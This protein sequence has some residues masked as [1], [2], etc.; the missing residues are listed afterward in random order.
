MKSFGR[1]GGLGL[2]RSG[3][4]LWG[5]FFVMGLNGF[6]YPKEYMMM[7]MMMMLICRLTVIFIVQEDE[8]QH[9]PHFQ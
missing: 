3:R 7:M 8:L 1:G 2:S 5:E 9:S 4:E 6:Y